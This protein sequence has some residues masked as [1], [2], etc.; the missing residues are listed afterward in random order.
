MAKTQINREKILWIDLEMTGLVPE[1]DVV[2]EL[3]AIVTDWKLN[4]IDEIQLVIRH[5]E[6]LLNNKF[7]KNLD[8]WGKFPE[9]RRQLIEQNHKGVSKDEFMQKLLK[10]VRKNWKDAELHT[11]VLAGNTIRTDRMFID[12]H[13]PEFAKYLH[14]RMLDVS[15]FKVYFDARFGKVYA[16]PENHRALEDIEGSIEEL[17]FLTKYINIEE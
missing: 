10:F 17:K 2:M 9:T 13:F 3:G 8:F 7:D 5:D 16:K 12:Y 4:K 6:G 1:N 14:Y 15:A 11:I